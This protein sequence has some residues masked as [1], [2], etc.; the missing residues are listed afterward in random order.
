MHAHV[1]NTPFQGKA[2]QRRAIELEF[3]KYIEK[4]MNIFRNWHPCHKAALLIACA[5]L[6]VV[7]A[8]YNM[9][10]KPSEQVSTIFEF[11]NSVLEQLQMLIVRSDTEQKSKVPF[12]SPAPIDTNT[13]LEVGDFCRVGVP[14][15]YP[16]LVDLR[17][18]VLVYNRHKSLKKLLDSLQDLVLDGDSARLEIFVDRI[19]KGNR[20]YSSTI[21]VAE[22]FKWRHGATRVHVRQRHTGLLGQ[23][24]YSWAPQVGTK[25]IALILEDDLSVSPYAYKWLRAVRNAYPTDVQGYSLQS[26]NVKDVKLKNR[27][28]L[29]GGT[30]DTVFMYRVLGTWGFAPHPESWREFQHWFMT[31]NASVK[32]YMPDSIITKWYKD[33]GDRNMWSIW[34]IYF[35]S[36]QGFSCVYNN[37]NFYLNTTSACLVV[38][39]QEKGLHYHGKAVNNIGNL[40][41][42]WRDDFE[43]FPE[44]IKRFN[45]NG[46]EM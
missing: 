34:H 16:E 42:F 7:L 38:N 12:T 25:E 5:A 44:A 46:T 45:Y 1:P 26:E 4:S 13:Q 24:I 33:S 9:L 22:K 23:W 36:S 41:R 10:N 31:K 37:L 35:S 39:R 43:Q 30:I 15:A 18:I 28:D 3:L 6:G 20:P 32:P 19:P 21:K 8:S 11:D 14:C 40:L 17:I 29:H 27:R 2:Y